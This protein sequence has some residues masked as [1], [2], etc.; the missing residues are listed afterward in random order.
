[1]SRA[2]RF[3]DFFVVAVCIFCMVVCIVPFMHV[4]SVSLSSNSALVSNSV[5]IFPKNLTFDPYKNVVFDLSTLTSLWLSVR[6]TVIYTIVS[7]IMTILCAYPLSRKK[8]MGRKVLFPMMLLTMY[9]SGGLIPTYLL[10]KDLNLLNNFWVLILPGCL[11]TYNMIILRSFF[12]SS[13]PEELVESAKLDGCSEFRLL[14]AIVLPLSKP[15]LA[16]L[17]LFYAVSRWNQFQDALFF[18]SSAKL[19][20]LQLRLYQIIRANASPDLTLLEGAT[21]SFVKVNPEA[22][23]AASIIFTMIPI[24]LVYPWLQKYFVKGVMIGA[25]KG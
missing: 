3:I 4:I 9:F 16:T 7:M 24:L 22:I 13:V 12:F 15:V 10:Y 19:Y 18:I 8:L 2:D 17:S 23:K 1:M 20:P 25:V 11:S 6:V 21:I 5:T 14:G